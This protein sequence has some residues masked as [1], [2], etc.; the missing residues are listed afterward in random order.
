MPCQ[1]SNGVY[2][3]QLVNSIDHCFVVDEQINYSFDFK[4]Y[5]LEHMYLLYGTISIIL[6]LMHSNILQIHT[7]INLNQ[8]YMIKLCSVCALFVKDIIYCYS[9]LILF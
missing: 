9:L 2:T 5:V 4:A 7:S 1:S 3:I 6:L 8:N